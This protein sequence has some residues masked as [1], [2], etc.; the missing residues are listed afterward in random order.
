MKKLTSS[1]RLALSAGVLLA[2]S[3]AQA[4]IT[5]PGLTITASNVNGTGTY[6]VFLSN[7]TWTTTNTPGDTWS[8]QSPVGGYDIFDTN[9]NVVAHVDNM[10]CQMIADPQI[11]VNFSVNSTSLATHFQI[12][13]GVLSFGG[14]NPAQGKATAGITITDNDGD[15]ASLTGLHA[16]PKAYRANYNGTIPGGTIFDNLVGNFVAAADDSATLSESSPAVGYSPIGGTV[17]DMQA[18]FDFILSA[19]DSASGTSFYE[20]IPSPA[21]ASLFGIAGL[22]SCGRRRR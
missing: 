4:G 21:A 1:M 16:G 17:T 20:I 18:E 13:S 11:T 8:W 19:N 14:I 6:Q 15:G 7:G 22:L 3:A 9:F 12:T 2:A 5:D 10:Y